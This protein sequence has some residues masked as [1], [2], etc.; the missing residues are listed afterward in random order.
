[1]TFADEIDPNVSYLNPG[2]T[3]GAVSTAI[4]GWEPQGLVDTEPAI[5][6]GHRVD[7][8]TAVGAS[9]DGIHQLFREDP[10]LV[11]CT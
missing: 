2:A 8:V 11:I 9:G 5:N 10:T 4:C 6:R 1:M 7:G 3:A